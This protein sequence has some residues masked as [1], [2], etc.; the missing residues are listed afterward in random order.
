MPRAAA[1]S[2]GLCAP[3]MAAS[4]PAGNEDGI[5]RP[6][7]SASPLGTRKV[8]TQAVGRVFP[9]KKGPFAQH[10]WLGPPSTSAL[11]LP[12]GGFRCN[13]P[14]WRRRHVVTLP[15][16]AERAVAWERVLVS[17]DRRG[18]LLTGAWCR[19]ASAEPSAGE[20]PQGP[21]CWSQPL[22][23]PPAGGTAYFPLRNLTG[24]PGRARQSQEVP[25]C[26][27]GVQGLWGP[28]VQ[29]Q[30]AND[31]LRFRAGQGWRGPACLARPFLCPG[32]CV[33]ARQRPG[34]RWW[35]RVRVGRPGRRRASRPRTR[36]GCAACRRA[37]VSLQGSE[38]PIWL[39]CV[40]GAVSLWGTRVPPWF[41]WH[42]A[43]LALRITKPQA[44]EVGA[45][46]S[47]GH[48]ESVW[49]PRTFRNLPCADQERVPAKQE[50]RKWQRKA[51]AG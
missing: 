2:G 27:C 33:H 38:E 6:G 3:P 35:P 36:W 11:L 16:T 5:G 14:S 23:G 9:Q 1:G 17:A 28:D 25:L 49:P 32:L 24:D 20:R 4:L 10:L 45:L 19:V 22:L 39:S 18:G 44:Q 30:L 26:V 7:P 12:S 8:R 50:G 37:A 51:L 31:T 48:H 21:A 42:R 15:H 29:L 47:T 41:G 34:A 40:W 46:R 13:P 43:L